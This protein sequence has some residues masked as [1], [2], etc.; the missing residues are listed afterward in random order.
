M[1]VWP[2]LFVIGMLAI[3]AC[4]DT[5]GPDSTTITFRTDP[6][7]CA[8]V[9]DF[10]ITIDGENQ[11]SFRFAPG[12]E[13]TFSV[14]SGVHSVKAESNQPE[15]GFAIIERDVTVPDGEDFAILLTCNA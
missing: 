2:I 6:V 15:S 12:S 11:G 5:S 8:N 13:W 7:T 3:L 14:E 10:E 1:R 9:V 4:D